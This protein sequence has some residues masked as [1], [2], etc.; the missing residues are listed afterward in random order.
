MEP[1]K[2]SLKI[3]LFLGEYLVEEV[4]PTQIA[5]NIG[6]NVRIVVHPLSETKTSLKRGDK[7]PLFT[8]IPLCPILQS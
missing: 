4:S 6:N 2:D 1:I 8:E 7:L 3:T 5:I